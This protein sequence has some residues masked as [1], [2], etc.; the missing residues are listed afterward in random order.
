MEFFFLINDWRGR[1]QTTIG[2]TTNRSVILDY[3]R[4][5]ADHEPGQ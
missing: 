3:I 2:G 1:A 4:K 5:Q